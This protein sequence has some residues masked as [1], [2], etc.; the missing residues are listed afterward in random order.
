MME[1]VSEWAHAPKV[2]IQN[3]FEM[4]KRWKSFL[5]P[6]LSAEL[7]DL[8]ESQGG[9]LPEAKYLTTWIKKASTPQSRL[10]RNKR[11]H[12]LY[13]FRNDA[14]KRTR[15]GL[16]EE[17]KG[18]EK[19]MAFRLHALR[20]RGRAEQK[21]KFD[22]ESEELYPREETH[23][24]KKFE[25]IAAAILRRF[26]PIYSDANQNLEKRKN[27]LKRQTKIVE[28]WLEGRNS[29][30][31][32]LERKLKIIIGRRTYREPKMEEHKNRC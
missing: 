24:S 12:F 14:W 15:G 21:K 26:D 7:D 23:H 28:G 13:F 31:K 22:R 5:T 1:K 20:H 18:E 16:A 9:V 8:G 27:R 10:T 2:R 3:E 11:S 32:I 6:W 29:R 25:V 30:L 17:K 4:Q 19:L